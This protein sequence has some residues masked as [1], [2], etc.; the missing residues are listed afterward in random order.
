MTAE[1]KDEDFSV[2]IWTR[3]FGREL[4]R[5]WPCF[6]PDR[7]GLKWEKGPKVVLMT[8]KHTIQQKQ[9]TRRTSEHLH[10]V[11]PS[12]AKLLNRNLNWRP[13]P[14]VRLSTELLLMWNLTPSKPSNNKNNS[15]LLR[16]EKRLRLISAVWLSWIKTQLNPTTDVLPELLLHSHWVYRQHVWWCLIENTGVYVRSS[17]CIQ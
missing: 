4:K 14:K 8:D 16:R 15:R 3:P 17:D 9:K 1:L 6:I 7:C 12:S 5:M 13:Y 11:K 10:R 2:F